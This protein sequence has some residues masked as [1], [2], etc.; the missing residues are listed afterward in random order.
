MPGVVGHGRHIQLAYRYAVASL[1]DLAE[2]LVQGWNRNG[3]MAEVVAGRAL[4][5]ETLREDTVPAFGAEA[6]AAGPLIR[7]THPL[8]RPAS[9]DDGAAVEVAPAPMAKLE[10]VFLA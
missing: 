4:V 6:V 10:L 5:L 8:G 7:N 2:E 1:Y 3:N 9:I